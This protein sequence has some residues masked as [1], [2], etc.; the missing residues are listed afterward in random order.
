[1]EKIKIGAKEMFAQFA[2]LQQDFLQK[3]AE[4][5]ESEDENDKDQNRR[6]RESLEKQVKNNVRPTV[7]NV[8][9][10][11]LSKINFFSMSEI[12]FEKVFGGKNSIPEELNEKME[13]FS[14][15]LN[16]LISVCR[17]LTFDPVKEKASIDQSENVFIKDQLRKQ[18]QKDEEERIKREA[19]EAKKR[20]EEERRKYEELSKDPSYIKNLQE[21]NRALEERNNIL[22]KENQQLKEQHEAD[23]QLIN[24]LQEQLDKTQQL[25]KKIEE[26]L[27][28]A[29]NKV[30]IEDAQ[31]HMQSE[32]LDN[33]HQ[34]INAMS[35]KNEKKE[36]FVT[37]LKA[38]KNDYQNQVSSILALYTN[39][40]SEEEK[41]EIRKVLDA[42]TFVGIEPHE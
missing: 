25:E 13:K 29:E 33:L 21:T 15:A 30:L 39:L 2:T 9:D 14:A 34:Q 42:D 7:E 35:L 31:V 40:Q 22:E 12:F 19:E 1:M 17:M 4:K 10:I 3:I 5:Y 16:L 11:Q 6:D 24:N 37:A 41:E 28:D 36:E 23:Q 32:L 26:Q 20:E 8:E 18:K 27:H 38:A